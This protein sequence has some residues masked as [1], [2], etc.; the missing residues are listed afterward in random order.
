MARIR[1]TSDVS[2][3]CGSASPS[4]ADRSWLTTPPYRRPK[5]CAQS[6]R[7]NLHANVRIA[8]RDREGIPPPLGHHRQHPIY[9]PRIAPTL[10]P[11]QGTIVAFGAGMDD[12]TRRK[13]E[14]AEAQTG[15]PPDPLPRSRETHRG[16][17]AGATGGAVAEGDMPCC[18]AQGP[19]WRPG[20]PGGVSDSSLAANCALGATRGVERRG[21]WGGCNG[22]T[23]TAPHA[24]D[25]PPAHGMPRG[26]TG[27]VARTRRRPLISPIPPWSLLAVRV[28]IH[29][30]MGVFYPG[31]AR[32]GHPRAADRGGT[33]KGDRAAPYAAPRPPR[34]DAGPS[35]NPGHPRSCGN[36]STGA[37]P[38]RG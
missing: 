38:P 31:P 19:H 20:A 23:G 8:G 24:L 7:F 13:I 6:D 18:V 29:L 35:E 3:A 12:T 9:P 16:R 15:Q 17:V 36:S 28:G 34:S 37:P 22:S 32:S 4:A 14:H 1:F 10:P 27:L 25:A 26:G 11:P 21:R 30:F 33:L 5:R 2:S